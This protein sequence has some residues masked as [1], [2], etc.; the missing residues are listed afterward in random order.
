MKVVTNEK[1]EDL[2]DKILGGGIVVMCIGRH[3]Q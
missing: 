3:V 1:R 2:E